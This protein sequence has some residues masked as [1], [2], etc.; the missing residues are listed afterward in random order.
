MRTCYQRVA[1]E[2]QRSPAASVRIQVTFDDTRRATAVD[3]TAP[4]WPAL[5]ACVRGVIEKSRVQN[6]PDVG[7]ATVIADIAFRPVAP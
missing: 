7:L 3:V 5:G 4:G 6:A 1:R 2:A